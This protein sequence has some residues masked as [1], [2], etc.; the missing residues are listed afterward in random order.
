MVCLSFWHLL[1][2]ICS[3]TSSSTIS[4]SVSG[5]LKF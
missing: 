4:I 2:A 3:L 5:L 1:F